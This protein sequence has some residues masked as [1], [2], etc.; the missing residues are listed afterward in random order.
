MSGIRMVRVRQESAALPGSA[1][2]RV[3][4]TVV[5]P[6]G[7]ARGGIVLLHETH[8]FS[9][10]LFQ[11]MEDLAEE[12][13]AVTAP[14]LFHRQPQSTDPVFGDALFEDFAAAEGWLHGEGIRPDCVGVL[15]FD[16]AGTAAALV[17]T[18][19]RIGAAVSIAAHG[20][21]E[22]VAAGTPPL[23]NAVRELRVPWLGIFGE[24][25]PLT[26]PSEIELLRESAARANVATLIVTYPGLGHRP[27][28]GFGFTSK[29]ADDVDDI[30]AT[31]DGSPEV[32]AVAA[33]QHIFEWFDSN[34]R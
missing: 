10:S 26:P 8:S 30:P 20:I 3:P 28:E 4:L 15:G 21:S 17:S 1:K 12:G 9:R 19:Q 33:R 13:W 29:G 5:E 22:P 34:L 6:E 32:A 7:R 23:V 24:D 25:D 31:G 11:F 14:D 27:D 2:Q 16:S 18:T